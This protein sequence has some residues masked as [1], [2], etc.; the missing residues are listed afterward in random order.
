VKN[1]AERAGGMALAAEHLPSKH[2]TLNSIPR[3]DKHQNTLGGIPGIVKSQEND[4]QK[5]AALEEIF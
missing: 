1:K 4:T 5:P 2:N 3:T